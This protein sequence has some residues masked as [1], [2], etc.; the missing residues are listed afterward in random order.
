MKFEINV[1][2]K[3]FFVLLGV[4]LIIGGIF[5]VIGAVSTSLPYHPASQ[6]SLSNGKDLQQAINDGSIGGGSEVLPDYILREDP[7]TSTA[8]TKVKELTVTERGTISVIFSLKTN[9]PTGISAYGRIYRNGVAVGTEKSTSSQSYVNQTEVISGWVPGDKL[10]LYIK[11]ALTSYTT[12]NDI[13]V[14]NEKS[15]EIVGGYVYST[16][17]NCQSLWGVT[18]GSVGGICSCPAGTTKKEETTA[19][20]FKLCV[21]N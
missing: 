3:R 5:G 11:N 20:G 7:I 4:I 1:T 9:A 10:Q 15:G 17:L 19:S 21:Q 6:V 16:T 14:M 8:Y 12:Y 18:I 2:K 13:L